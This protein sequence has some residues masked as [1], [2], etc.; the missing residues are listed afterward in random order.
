MLRRLSEPERLGFVLSRLSESA[1]L[2]EAQ[3]EPVA[4]VDR[5]GYGHSQILVDQVGGQRCEVSGGQLDNPLVVAP[6][7]MHLLEIHRGLN[8]EPQVPEAPRDLQRPGAS[9][10]R[11]V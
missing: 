2:G 5:W 1:E 8:A 6:I 3:E 7:A 11:L 9:H 10:K 4:I